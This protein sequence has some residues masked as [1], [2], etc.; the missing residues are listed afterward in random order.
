MDASSERLAMGKESVSGWI[1]R[2][3]MECLEISFHRFL[4]LHNARTSQSVS[5]SET[6]E[7]LRNDM[8]S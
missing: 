4:L 2:S 7:G 6:L 3:G 5:H 1:L 8:W